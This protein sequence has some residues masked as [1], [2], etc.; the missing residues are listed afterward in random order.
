MEPRTDNAEISAE[1]RETLIAELE[2]AVGKEAVDRADVDVDR[3]ISERPK[4]MR[5]AFASSRLLI[6]LSGA[7]AL[8]VGVI[9]S[10][11]LGSWWL[12]AAALL[13]HGLL[14]AVVVGSSMTLIS[15]V[16]KPDAN[17]V[18]QLE[19]QGVE[20]PELVINNLIEQVAG[21]TE[22]SR[23]RRAVTEDTGETR[24]TEEDRLEATTRQQTATTP[25]SEATR[26][27]DSD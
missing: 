4:P 27:A 19:Q 23:S 26:T 16:E 10:L 3:A 24:P 2:D 5:S 11:A 7:T 18:T 25:A 15:Q 22:G 14:T 13:V 17:V 21:E 9:A 12:V 20:D 6:I 1:A 8:T